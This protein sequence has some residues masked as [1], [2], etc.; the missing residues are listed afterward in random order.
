MEPAPKKLCTEIDSN[1][2]YENDCINKNLNLKEFQLK[3]ILN[4]FED[5]CSL[6]IE[7]TFGKSPEK[8]V[9][10]LQVIIM[11]FLF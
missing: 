10:L 3:G 7:G 1:T 2:K 8:A 11:I 9:I 5:K 4:N 6:A